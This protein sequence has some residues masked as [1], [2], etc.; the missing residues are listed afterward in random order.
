MALA[1]FAIASPEPSRSVSVSR[2]TLNAERGWNA[3]WADAERFRPKN[4]LNL[5]PPRR[6]QP[7]S[8]GTT[9]NHSLLFADRNTH[10]KIVTVA[11]LA[12]IM[13]VGAGIF[14]HVAQTGPTNNAPIIVKA[15]KPATYSH[16]DGGTVR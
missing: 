2:K 15:G 4:P 14:T 11:L 7:T 16:A 8:R 13:V 5:F 3:G 1:K 12:A 9:M 6:D 10:L